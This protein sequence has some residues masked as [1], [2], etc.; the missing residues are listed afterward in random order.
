MNHCR[1]R[2]IVGPIVTPTTGQATTSQAP[3]TTAT[4][5]QRDITTA[6]FTTAELTTSGDITTGYYEPPVVTTEIATTAEE[7][8][9]VGSILIPLYSLVVFLFN[10]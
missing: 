9:S 2:S 3:L 8:D 4:P 10:I 7:V 5:S 1:G 6:G